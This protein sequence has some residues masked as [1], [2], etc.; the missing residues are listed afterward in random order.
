M[1]LK[2]ANLPEGVTIKGASDLQRQ[3]V[4]RDLASEYDHDIRSCLEQIG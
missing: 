3:I 4:K 2:F 1:E